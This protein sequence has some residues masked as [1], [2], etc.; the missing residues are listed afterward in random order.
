MPQPEARSGLRAL[1]GW[2]LHKPTSRTMSSA[3]RS[4]EQPER[5]DEA[6]R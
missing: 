5:E 3:K 4:I 1:A 6:A 2:P